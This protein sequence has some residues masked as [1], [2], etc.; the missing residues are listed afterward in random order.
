MDELYTQ[1]LSLFVILFLKNIVEVLQPWVRYKLRAGP[2]EKASR[3]DEDFV[4]DFDKQF[5]LESYDGVDSEGSLQDYMELVIMLGYTTLFAVA[6]PLSSFLTYV[7][8]LI[9]IQVDKFKL[10]HLVRRPNPIGGKTIGVWQSI[11]TFNCT[12]AIFTNIGIICFTI[13]A[14]S[15]WSLTRDNMYFTYTLSVLVLLGVQWLIQVG[16]PDMPKNFSNI[17][18]RHK[19]IVEKKLFNKAENE[20]ISKNFNLP[21]FL[22]HASPLDVDDNNTFYN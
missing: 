16:I 18:K 21:N 9:E 5:F 17:F 15:Q 13:P 8:I 20:S 7:A 14:M 6:F 2:N 19:H 22:V 11:F 3:P 10:V 12:A 1:L 4:S